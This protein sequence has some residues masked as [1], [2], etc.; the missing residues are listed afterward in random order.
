[1]LFI[2]EKTLLLLSN[3]SFAIEILILILRKLPNY[4]EKSSRCFFTFEAMGSEK[5][6]FHLNIVASITNKIFGSE[7]QKFSGISRW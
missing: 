3:Y 7:N 4:S 2:T 6:S 1:M 5:F